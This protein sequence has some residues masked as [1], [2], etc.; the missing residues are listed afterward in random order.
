MGY[1]KNHLLPNETIEHTG[2][3]TFLYLLPK[4]LGMI[5]FVILGAY[6]IE[7]VD[8]DLALISFIIAGFE[9]IG[10]LSRVITCLTSEF[11]ITNKRI[12]LKRGFISRQVSDI[13]LD[14]CDGVSFSQGFWGRI[15]GFGVV[16]T[17][18]TGRKGQHYPALAHPN[19]FRNEL[20]RII[21]Q[22]KA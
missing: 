19:E 20:F 16:E 6:L 4:L 7:E 15:W 3:T 9:F 12:C 13:A 21:D 17:S 18:S 2:K 14:K 5:V 22:Q 11:V 1:V 8:E 10:L